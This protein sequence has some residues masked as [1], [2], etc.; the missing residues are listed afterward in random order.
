MTH[1]AIRPLMRGDLPRV[2]HLVDANAMF[3]SEMLDDMTAAYFVGDSDTQRWIVA[4]TGTVTGVAYTVPEPLTE[5]TWNTLCI[6]VDP[7]A[8]G[9]GIG[10]AL[11]RH[12]ESDLGGQG[13][14]VLLVETSGTPAFERTRGFY[15]MLGY[16]REARIR[17]YYSAGDD[18]IIFRK[19]LV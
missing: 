4:D 18:K 5:G 13:A 15:D 10:S 14:R 3:P 16:E 1:I 11:V 2:A 8:H 12:I 9:Q 7:E 19:A 17:D 6:C